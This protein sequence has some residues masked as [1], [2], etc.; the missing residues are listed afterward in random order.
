[1]GLILNSIQDH[2]TILIYDTDIR[3]TIIKENGDIFAIF[4]YFSYRKEVSDCKFSTSFK[5]AN[6]LPI[7]KK[8]SRLEEK[9][10]CRISILPNLSKYTRE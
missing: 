1:M 10:Y 6:V 3:S 7:C 5:N 8:D 9:N 2:S 4:L